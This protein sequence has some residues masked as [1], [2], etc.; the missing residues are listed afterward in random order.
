MDRTGSC[1]D[2]AAAES[3]F[4]PLRAEIGTT[5]WDTWD[6]AR[7]DVFRFIEV[8]YHRSR[9]RKHPGQGCLTPLGTR[10][11]PLQDLTPAA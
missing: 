5:V 6:R 9:L 7:A 11:L 3:F 8:E 4:G 1:Y 10:A 2:K